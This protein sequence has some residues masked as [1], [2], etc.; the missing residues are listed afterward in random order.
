[1]KRV[2]DYCDRLTRLNVMFAEKEFLPDEIDQELWTVCVRIWGHTPDDVD[3]EELPAEVQQWLDKVYE[4]SDEAAAQAFAT[5]NGYDL[6]DGQKIL[7]DWW[8]F[9]LMILAEKHDIF[10]PE[11]IAAARLKAEAAKFQEDKEA[12]VI[13]GD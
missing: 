9:L 10:Q 12:G 8:S 5:D 7:S 1:M 3:D 13:Q 11:L 6:M 4:D 2:A